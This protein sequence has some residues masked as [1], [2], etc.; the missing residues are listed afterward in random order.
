MNDSPD[1]LT[2]LSNRVDQL[3]SRVYHLEH[4]A[5]TSA[6]VLAAISTAIEVP[7]ATEPLVQAGTIFPVLGRAMLGMAG[8]YALR[9]LAESGSFPKLAAVSLAIAYAAAWLI[10]AVR[11]PAEKKFASATYAAT[12]ALILAPML[13]ELTLSFRFLPPSSA[14]AVLAAYLC[15]TY[16]LAWKRRLTPVLWVA[17]LTTAIAAISLLIATREM[18]PFLAVLLLMSLLTEATASRNDVL[19]VRPIAAIAA[20]IAIWALLFTYSSP[21]SNRPDYPSLNATALLT[22]AFLLLLIYG[23]SIALGTILRRQTITVFETGQAILAFLLAAN[24]VLHF[25]SAPGVTLFGIACLLLSAAGYTTALLRFDSIAERLNYH[26]YAAWSAALLLLGC[27]WSVPAAWLPFCLG[28]A[29]IAAAALGAKT[30][31]LTLSFHG[32][33]YLIAAAWAADAFDYAARALAGIFPAPPAIVV[34]IV[35]AA[36]ILCYLVGAHIPTAHWKH[37][38]IQLLSA[39]LAVTALATTLISTL[40]WLTATVITP[41]ASH[42]AVIRTLA[43]CALALTLAFT[44]SRW[45][46]IELVWIAYATLALVT[47]KLLFEDLR[48]GH[49][50]FIAAS[51]FLYALTLILVPRL[52]RKVSSKSPSATPAN[53]IRIAEPR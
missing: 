15:A 21:E 5:E 6:A 20:D 40:V 52:V 26:V 43:A 28:A 12:S 23:A 18:L 34:W 38:L 33:A 35:S 17:T 47:A 16:A 36:A 44:G 8:A 45:Q 51:I 37:H 53:E 25:A 9:A 48:Q 10:G 3:E 42:V 50:E 30:S 46:R 2:R 49:P 19:S 39:S 29:A 11:V 4:P 7:H 27:F 13:W 41:G 31:L 22:P 32:V 24:A 1:V 14:A